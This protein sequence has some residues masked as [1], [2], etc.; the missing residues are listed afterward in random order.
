MTKKDFE[1]IYKIAVKLSEVLDK[2][3]SLTLRIREVEIEINGIKQ[4]LVRKKVIKK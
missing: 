3:D 2:I 4:T 1:Y